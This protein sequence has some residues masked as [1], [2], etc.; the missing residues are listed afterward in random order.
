MNP[1]DRDSRPVLALTVRARWWPCHPLD[2]R[3]LAALRRAALETRDL[4]KLRAAVTC[5]SAGHAFETQNFSA[6]KAHWKIVYRAL[7]QA[8][9]ERWRALVLALRVADAPRAG[10]EDAWLR[11]TM[12]DFQTPIADAGRN[13]YRLRTVRCEWC[14]ENGRLVVPYALVRE[15]AAARRHV[16]LSLCVMETTLAGG[17]VEALGGLVCA[18]RAL[19]VPP[20]AHPHT[21]PPD[22]AP[23]RAVVVPATDVE[24]EGTERIPRVGC[25]VEV[26]P[27]DAT[28][29]PALAAPAPDA[30]D[31][32]GVPSTPRGWGVGDAAL[33]FGP[34]DVGD[35]PWPGAP[36]AWAP[37]PL[38]L[39]IP[40]TPE[41][42]QWDE[43]MLGL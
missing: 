28:P 14:I 19:S 43:W 2:A 25:V 34:G 40:A 10:P 5:D 13:Y 7:G 32:Y 17:A 18:P 12:A 38:G 33:L 24:D 36:D 26:V 4:K 37:N 9:R 15:D 21:Q 16:L 20:R 39:A 30:P 29:R 22:P 42:V 23:H 31:V 3:W 8:A 1:Y 35:E 6:L 27:A 41:G 11:G